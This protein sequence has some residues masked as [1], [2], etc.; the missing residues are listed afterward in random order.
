MV[1]AFEMT[2]KV[3]KIFDAQNENYCSLC[4]FHPVLRKHRPQKLNCAHGKY[5]KRL[6]EKAERG[7]DFVC[8]EACPLEARLTLE[9]T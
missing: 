7:R 6:H 9:R 2:L 1:K 8:V 3:E 4:T 5:N